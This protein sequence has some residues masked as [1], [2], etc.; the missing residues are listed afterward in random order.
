MADLLPIEEIINEIKDTAHKSILLGNGFNSALDITSNYSD[1]FQYLINNCGGAYKELTDPQKNKIF[2][3]LRG[4]FRPLKNSSGHFED[5]HDE[6]EPWYI[7]KS[8]EAIKMDLVKAILNNKNKKG[9]NSTQ[10]PI[11]ELLKNGNFT[12]YFTVN[13]DPFFFEFFAKYTQLSE[14]SSRK[15]KKS[16][17]E[18]L[19]NRRIEINTAIRNA[20]LILKLNQISQSRDLSNL[21]HETQAIILAYFREYFKI[22]QKMNKS[23]AR[24][25]ILKYIRNQAICARNAESESLE[26]RCHDG[27]VKDGKISS[28]VRILHKEDSTELRQNLFYLHGS[29]YIFRNK[30]DPQKVQKITEVQ[31]EKKIESYLKDQRESAI[32]FNPTKNINEKY[33]HNNPYL[34]Y[35]Y[36]QLAKLQGILVIYGM[37]FPDRDQHIT[38]CIA[39]NN[40][41]KIYISL[42]LDDSAKE[43]ERIKKQFEDATQE[44]IFFRGIPGP[45]QKQGCLQFQ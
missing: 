31:V 37:S 32:V 12:H 23:A 18:D 43:V 9:S 44:L 22:T 40:L 11:L 35:C 42:F 34:V 25:I 38:R 26:I 39:K 7:N 41:E 20:R 4:L 14:V 8:N 10:A 17:E 3:D 27:F 29:L 6:L 21:E 33:I 28:F 36:E 16:A 2:Q 15:R 5:T 45:T 30:D 24:D 13:F 19:Q 1:W